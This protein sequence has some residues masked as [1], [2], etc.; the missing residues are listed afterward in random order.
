METLDLSPG[1]MPV[2]SAVVSSA[3][4]AE[5]ATGQ[6]READDHGHAAW[7]PSRA[8]ANTTGD[9]VRPL[10]RKKATCDSSRAP[11]RDSL[12]LG[13]PVAG[14]TAYYFFSAASSFLTYTVTL[15]SL[16]IV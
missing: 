8:R 7:G 16:R 9:M 3:E 4:A 5:R 1:R 10:A 15:S 12:R 14:S 13:T 11:K 6:T 2:T